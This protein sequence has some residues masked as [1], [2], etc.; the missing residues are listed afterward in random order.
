MPGNQVFDEVESMIETK[1]GVKWIRFSYIEH[2]C[3]Y[4][5]DNYHIVD[6]NENDN[7]DHWDNDDNDDNND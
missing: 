6:N 4:I 7:N 5:D 3:T 1:G 2:M